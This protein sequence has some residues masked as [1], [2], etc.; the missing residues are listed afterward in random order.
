MT[1]EIIVLASDHNG[2]ELKK[3]LHTH[4]KILGYTPID[5]GPYDTTK[6]VDY[7]DYAF[8]LGKIINEGDVKKGILI[9]GTGVGMSIAANRFAN[10]RAALV[11][12]LETAPKCREH[13]DSNVLCLGAWNTTPQIAEK[14]L[15]TWLNTCFG[16]GRHVPRVEKISEHKQET[17]VFTN[18]IFDVLHTG[19]IELLNFAKSLG[20]KLIV[21]INSDRAVK[22][23]KGENRPIN[24][25]EDRKKVIGS[26]GGV[27]Q[28]IIFDDIE[29]MNI[30]NQIK[31]HVVVKGG[32]WTAEE[33]RKRDKIP[34]EISVRIFPLMR[35]YSSAN[36]LTKI[37]E[38]ENGKNFSSCS[39][40]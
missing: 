16:E 8:Q 23:L 14:I 18:G 31:P 1:S 37:K 35:E 32:E 24:N 5:L 27:D 4:I 21:A 36:I 25:Q 11:H 17:I 13:N 6:K 22:E 7:T 15:E 3:H 2:V 9:C 34:D 38:N 33:V 19:H 12:N 26:I 20:D 39:C 29:T 30:I 40:E 10:V 28:V